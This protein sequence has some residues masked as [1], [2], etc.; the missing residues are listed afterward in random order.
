MIRFLVNRP[1]GVIMSFALLILSGII[2]SQKIPISLFPDSNFPKLDIIIDNPGQSPEDFDN[3]IVQKVRNNLLQVSSIVDIN[4]YSNTKNG[5]VELIFD[6]G[7]NLDLIF[8]EVNEK[9][10]ETLSDLPY[11]INR[12]KVVKSNLSEIPLLY[13]SVTLKDNSSISFEDLSSFVNGKLKNRL[14]Q[15]YEVSFVDMTGLSKR[16]IQISIDEK[17][18][19]S[20]GITLQEVKTAIK[21]SSFVLGNVQ[22]S[23]GH[24]TYDLSIENSINS[25]DD[26]GKITLL[27]DHKKITLSEI[28]D[29]KN[30]IKNEDE[31]YHDMNKAISLAVIK[32]PNSKESDFISKLNS[33]IKNIAEQNENIIISKTNDKTVILKD[34]MM[35]LTLSLVL[36]IV[37]TIVTTF[38]F[39]KSSFSNITIILVT[40]TTSLLI[41]LFLFYILDISINLI[42]ISGLILGVGLMIDNIIIV[43]DN[44]EQNSKIANNISKGTIQ[45]V[46]EIFTA[47]IS[48]ALTTCSIFIPLIFMSGLAGILFYDQ[49]I[50]VTIALTSSFFVSVILLPTLYILLKK[51]SN[52]YVFNTKLLFFYEKYYDKI[53]NNRNSVILGITIVIILGITSFILIDKKQLP[54]L[55]SSELAFKVEW[56]QNLIN[57]ELI[58]RSK[59]ILNF[60]E[61]NIESS[62]LYLNQQNFLSKTQ[63]NSIEDYESLYFVK[64]KKGHDKEIIKEEMV[65]KLRV[66]FPKSSIKFLSE[67]NALNSIL[68]N[69][70]YNLRVISYDDKINLETIKNKMIGSFPDLIFNLKGKTERIKVNI[71]D[72]KLFIYGIDKNEIIE[73]IKLKFGKEKLLN[74]NYGRTRIPVTFL[75]NSPELDSFLKTKF[76]NNNGISYNLKDLISLEYEEYK[77]G[78]EADLGGICNI[79]YVKSKKPKQV[80][81][82]IR[83]TFPNSPISF[84]GTYKL[85]E[86]LQKEIFFIIIT[87]FLLLYLILAIQ[88]DSLKL[89]LIILSEVPVSVSVALIFLYLSDNTLNVMSFI[90][91][92]VMSGIIINDSILKIDLIKKLLINGFTIDEAIN[93][94][95]KR[96]LNAIVM[97][98]LTTILATL[99]ILFQNE[100]STQ[101]QSPLIIS[102]IGGLLAGT[103]MSIFIVPI[104]YKKLML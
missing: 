96:R 41:D 72:D 85:V 97:T 69:E 27:I 92:I 9:I 88:F 75:A 67:E 90:G 104:L 87:T 95:G 54:E 32:N 44:V 46:N 14:E 19:N 56:N 98:S 100:L 71:D 20:L 18:I 43:L 16:A 15:L 83:K 48:S 64:V 65:S 91:M 82:F 8:F 86:K 4:S 50:S 30:V 22:I 33:T 57:K 80:I 6:Y 36:G 61:N 42:S 11:K 37:L 45:G 103:F 79:L 89:P 2:L 76:I 17:L 77:K 66:K 84:E 51:E 39:L 1:I 35:N 40:I 94:A 12:P 81:D 28:A 52:Q 25:L 74:I 10:D 68:V 13:L 58:K 59:I 53:N 99:P 23:E 73:F 62:E 70:E 93:S 102:L 101:L 34:T 29:I 38:F 63:R 60:L 21:E 78:V 7:S 49:A 5:K 24:F 3:K 31:Y 55:Q 26:I 47:L